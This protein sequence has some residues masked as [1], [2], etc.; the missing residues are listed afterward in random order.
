M[1]RVFAKL[2]VHL[3]AL[4]R[5][6]QGKWYLIPL[7][8]LLAGLD[9]FLVVLPID[10]LVIACTFLRPKRWISCAVGFTIGST[11]GAL[12]L[13]MALVSGLEPW[14]QAQAPELF[15]GPHVSQVLAWIHQY[16]FWPVVLNAAL[17]VP[18]TP[19]IAAAAFAGLA[20]VKVAAAYALGRA[21]KYGILCG[22]VSRAPHLLARWKIVPP[23]PPPT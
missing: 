22:I 3:L 11:I 14:L 21:V 9:L 19:L 13:S 18:Q 16:G 6:G 1:K 4:P 17:P 23:E 8:S 2:R 7:C 20:P 10:P 15:S 5:W 12:A